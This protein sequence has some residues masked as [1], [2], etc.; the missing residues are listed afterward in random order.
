MVPLLIVLP[1]ILLLVFII[2]KISPHLI[3]PFLKI[4]YFKQI[5][6]PFLF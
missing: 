4:D 1:G 5:N 2:A 3:K 6:F